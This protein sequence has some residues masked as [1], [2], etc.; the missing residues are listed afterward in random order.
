MIGIITTRAPSIFKVTVTRRVQGNYIWDYFQCWES[1]VKK[2][3]REEMK[4]SFRCTTHPS[5]KTPENVTQILTNATLCLVWT[6]PEFSVPK[7]LSVNTDQTG[8]Q[9]SPGGIATWAPIGSK[10]V[11]VVGKD[12]QRSFTLVVGISMSGE[13][14]PFQVVYTGKTPASLPTSSAPNYI[15]ATEELK[16]HFESSGNDTYWSTVKTM[17]SYVTNILVPYFESHCQ[18][19]GL[20]NQLCIWQID[21]W[22]VHRSLEF[23]TWVWC[24]NQIIGKPSS[25]IFAKILVTSSQIIIQSRIKYGR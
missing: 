9:Y 7:P 13:V 18:R 1:F 4:W 12:E 8:F 6:I 19:L 16:F 25:H 24:H 10:Q 20:P 2:F 23:H 5:K 22:S 14:L 17:Q 11:E 15:R 3:L 21:A